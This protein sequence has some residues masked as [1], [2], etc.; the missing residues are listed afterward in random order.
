MTSLP[1]VAVEWICRQLPHR[2]ESRF[3]ERLQ[4]FPDGL[5]MLTVKE[6]KI[7]SEALR[8]RPCLASTATR[9]LPSIAAK[10][11][12]VQQV[13]SFF[14][15]DESCATINIEL[16]DQLA[17][18]M[19]PSRKRQGQHSSYRPQIP[20]TP[21]KNLPPLAPAGSARSDRAIEGAFATRKVTASS[22][23]SNP[24]FSLHFNPS[25]TSRQAIQNDNTTTVAAYPFLSKDTRD[26]NQP[27]SS[28]RFS[29][30]LPSPTTKELN[31]QSL[32]HHE[33]GD[34]E[35]CHDKSSEVN[36]DTDSLGIV[37]LETSSSFFDSAQNAKEAQLLDELTQMGFPDRR[38]ILN[39]IRSQ[40]E[41]ITALTSDQVMIWIVEQ[42]EEAA[43]A[44]KMD[45]A[46]LESEK[47][48]KQQE[49]RQKNSYMQ[50]LNMA[51]TVQD[52]QQLFHGSWILLQQNE[53]L[54]SILDSNARG[55]FV[56]LLSMENKAK[57]W[58][59]KL[60]SSY[61]IEVGKSLAQ[62]HVPSSSSWISE[63]CELLRRALY[64]LD[65]QQ[66]G[67]PKLFLNT[68]RQWNA[69]LDEGVD[70]EVMLVRQSQAPIQNNKAE[71]QLIIELE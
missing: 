45:L 3:Q 1:S 23:P 33:S 42:R 29:N 62:I 13:R 54:Q 20:N 43:E 30:H 56:E 41:P 53:R 11:R 47:L 22:D 57:K 5:E 18:E 51:R 26:T 12:R 35:C 28:V 6:L 61:F 49:E 55:S 50:K 9:S 40:H 14:Y 70:D 16:L 36:R 60:P 8:T 21:H 39:G 46:R 2:T 25:T 17:A 65:Q 71:D 66:G 10:S 15:T 64:C 31:G 68:A 44:Q 27:I 48:R 58:Y 63:K 24:K 4:S 7:L 38:E 67:V 59:G 34:L 52:F 69:G 32:R 19:R 37:K